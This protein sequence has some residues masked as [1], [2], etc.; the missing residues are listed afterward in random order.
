MT[1][2]EGFYVYIYQDPITNLPF[3]IG[4]GQKYRAHK[5]RHQSHNRPLQ[6]KIR[7]LEKSGNPP[8]I[9][10]L[11]MPSEEDAFAY[12]ELFISIYG[13]RIDGSGSLFN[14][15][16]GGC[17]TV[18][19]SGRKHSEES[20]RKISEALRGKKRSEETKQKQRE[21]GLARDVSHLHSTENKE[22]LRKVQADPNYRKRMSLKIKEIVSSEHLALMTE[23]AKLVVTGGKAS[24]ETRRKMSEVAKKRV[25][26]EEAR[27]NMS[28][29]QRRRYARSND[30]F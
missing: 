15:S 10:I 25:V 22:K 29:G 4:K 1:V 14:I 19:F 13:K 8:V 6:M 11:P 5:H 24:L 16:D 21:A 26:T 9:M 30:G 27:K 3:Y 23:R 12:E 28:L 17:K 7:S 2:P 18:G 20:R